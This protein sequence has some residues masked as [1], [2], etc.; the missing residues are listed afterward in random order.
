MRAKERREGGK[1][2]RERSKSLSTGTF[3]PNYVL[4]SAI[5]APEYMVVSMYRDDNSAVNI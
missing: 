1:R 5:E 3:S 4:M 2:A